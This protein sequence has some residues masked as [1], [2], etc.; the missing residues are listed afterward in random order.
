[1]TQH[2]RKYQSTRGVA[3]IT[4]IALLAMFMTLGAIWFS[5]MTTDNEET[6]LALANTRAQLYANGGAYIRLGDLHK[7]VERGATDSIQLDELLLELPVYDHGVASGEPS[8]RLRYRSQTTVTVTDEN[9]R[10]NINHAPPK[11]LRRLLNV[12]GQTAR[13]IRASLPVPG[14]EEN[15][16]KRWLTS[17]DELVTRGFMTPKE[18]NAVNPNLI[19]VYTVSDESNPHRFINV[20]TASPRVLQAILDLRPQQATSVIEARPFYTV[21]EL[22]QAT[23]KEA[24]LFNT[25]PPDS[26]NDGLPP[27]LTFKSSCF[28]IVAV[29][30]L[31]HIIPGIKPV[32]EGRARTEA[33]VQFDA[34]GQPHIQYWSEAPER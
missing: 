15:A 21:A 28:R 14:A 26:T 32:T 25:R 27:E 1:M 7:A 10:I 12:D 30:E 22:V 4:A 2:S 29:S 19:T 5:E 3:L 34:D 11:V 23:G 8:W 20:N 31:Q 16:N 13:A 24:A 9:A 6:D 18:L 33:V 17:V